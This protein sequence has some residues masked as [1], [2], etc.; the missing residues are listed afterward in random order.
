MWAPTANAYWYPHS[1]KD[2][3]KESYAF[4]VNNLGDIT[5]ENK[6]RVL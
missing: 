4:H 1:G 2:D 6:T 5:F 3:T